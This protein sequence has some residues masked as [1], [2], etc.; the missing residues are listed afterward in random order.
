ENGA[1]C[2]SGSGTDPDLGGVLLLRRLRLM[3]NDRRPDVVAFA[4]V[5]KR[6]EPIRDMSKA[7]HA[8]RAF[9][10]RHRTNDFGTG[11]YHLLGVG[12]EGFARAGPGRGVGLSGG[13]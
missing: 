9:D 12:Q 2:R 1:D 11:G 10:V 3:R 4:V 13:G 5:P 8:A 6:R 7:L